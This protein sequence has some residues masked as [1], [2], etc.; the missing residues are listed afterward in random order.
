MDQTDIKLQT[1]FYG[2]CKENDYPQKLLNQLQMV[3][4]RAK[5]NKS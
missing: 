2:A 3:A 1:P 4:Q 5:T